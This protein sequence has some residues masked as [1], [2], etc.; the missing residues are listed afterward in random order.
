MDLYLLIERTTLDEDEWSLFGI[1]DS[2]EKAIAAGEVYK[3]NCNYAE[4]F[5]EGG[6][7]YFEI[8]KIKCNEL[9]N[10]GGYLYGFNGL[11]SQSL[12]NLFDEKVN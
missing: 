10:Y 11:P 6:D 12:Q 3:N 5:E 7:Q 1:F 8:Q 4:D 9:N 2:E